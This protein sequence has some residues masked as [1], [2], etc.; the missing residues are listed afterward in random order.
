[1]LTLTRT[2]LFA[3]LAVALG[4]TGVRADDAAVDF[5]LRVRPI[6]SKHC[7][8]CHGPDAGHRKAGLRLDTL[9]GA[10]ARLESSNRGVVPRDPDASEVIRRI[11][12]SDPEKRMPH[13]KPALD[14]DEIELIRQ[15]IAGGAEWSEHWAFVKPTR[16]L[17]PKTLNTARSVRNAIDAFIIAQLDAK[18]L[19]PSPEADKR[20]LIRRLTLDLTGLPPTPQEINAF[21]ADDSPEAYERLVDRLMA[22]PR[23]GERMAWPWLD[24]ARYADT[25]GYQGDPTRNMWPWRD[26]VVDAMNANMPYDRF[27]IEQLAGDQLPNATPEQ[28]FASAFNRN[29]MINGEGGRIFEETRVENVF[30]RAETT[31]T[32]WLGLTFQCARCHDHKF[33]PL[34]IDDYFAMYDFFNQTSDSGRGGGA[35]APVMKYARPADRAKLAALDKQIAALQ[36]KLTAPSPESDKAQTAWEATRAKSSV[37]LWQTLD[38]ADARSTNGATISKRDDGTLHVTGK[39]PERDVYEFKAATTLNGVTAI[40]LDALVDPQSLAK[41]NGRDERG[42]FVLSEIELYARPLNAPDAKPERVKFAEASATHSQKGFD[43]AKAIDGKVHP[44]D[45]WAS[46]GYLIKKPQSATFILA[47]PLAHAGGSEL[48]FRLRFESQHTHHTLA[49]FR[50][51]ASDRPKAE[52]GEPS[53]ADPVEALIAKPTDQRNRAERAT[54]RDHYRRNYSPA[55]KAVAG[56]LDALR[57]QREAAAKTHGGVSV[58]V[59]DTIGKPR[60]T[61]VLVK[62]L[63]NDKTKRTITANTPAFLPALPEQTDGKRYTRLDLATWIV[64]PDN[65]L[66]ARVT[67]NRYWQTFFGKGIVT[68]PGDLGLQGDRPTHPKLLD[69]LAV[70]FVQSKWNVKHMHKLIVMSAT[71]RQSSRVTPAMLEA[72][73][74]NK[75]LGRSPR[76]RMPS[77]MLRDQ[78]LAVSGLLVENVGGP[79]VMPY[80]PSGIWAEATFGKKR[81]SQ[82]KG[83]A[84]YRR[85]MYTFWRRIVGPTM[86]FD[87][88]RRQTCEV[89]P[90]LTNTPLH[91]LTTLNDV[92]HVEAARVFAER[93]MKAHKTPTDRIARAF[94]TLTGRPPIAEEVSVLE[95]RLNLLIARYQKAPAEAT[96]LLAMGESKRDASLDAPEHAAYTALFNMMMNL[97][98]ALVKP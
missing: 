32:V 95:R 66:T 10:T 6:L 25:S 37:T 55:F 21:L 54:L 8:A 18:G 20:T 22:S 53:A 72:D 35:V 91:A 39:R 38:P 13:D 62:G 14:P 88:S 65:P 74:T 76:F 45:G 49:L 47:A 80:H 31:G 70:E 60:P 30:D 96:K 48:T 64:S 29:H 46:Q 69:W 28:R 44:N 94:E 92:Q 87:S 75:L 23:Y 84:L 12:H 7:L 15:W 11:T 79:P 26:W 27:T 83:D 58:M 16:P 3:L 93:T 68:T 57:K 97:D 71:Y 82:G 5:D 59:M 63:Y 4:S 17:V 19:S 56:E 40:R 51:S 9:D 78:A 24:A 86:F 89:K 61:H 43:P 34:G 98:E 2:L 67:V 41:S 73:P 85:S 33:D 36:T 50:L 52:L 77:W 90:N 1:M 42:N 81:Y